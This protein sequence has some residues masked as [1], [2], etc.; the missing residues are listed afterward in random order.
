MCTCE[1]RNGVKRGGNRSNRTI[2]VAYIAD[3]VGLKKPDHLKPKAS[4]PMTGYEAAFAQ[5]KSTELSSLRTAPLKNE[6]EY[7]VA[8]RFPDNVASKTFN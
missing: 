6:S 7:T 8:M 1:Q 4:L 2:N 3:L 5:E